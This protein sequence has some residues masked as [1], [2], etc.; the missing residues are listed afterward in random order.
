MEALVVHPSPRL[1]TRWGFWCPACGCMH[2]FETDPG[3]NPTWQFTGDINRPTF[4]PSLLIYVLTP[5]KVPARKTICH[6]F[7]RDGRIE[8]CADHP[9]KEF[10]GKT[11]DMIPISQLERVEYEGG[12][13][14]WRTK[15][16]L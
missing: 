16:S 2:S 11:V 14:A 7:V 6:L 9:N 1:L 4:S 15:G 8:Y 5:D 10:S 3:A 12:S 13:F